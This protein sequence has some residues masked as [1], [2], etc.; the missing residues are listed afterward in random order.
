MGDEAGRVLSMV[1]SSVRKHRLAAA[2]GST[3]P[4][5]HLGQKRPLRLIRVKAEGDVSLPCLNGS[6]AIK[7]CPL[8]LPFTIPQTSKPELIPA[9]PACRILT[10][11]ASPER[12]TGLETGS[13]ALGDGIAVPG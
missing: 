13:P 2:R 9:R 11:V 8:N 12:G 7:G 10:P 4:A 5:T 1:A 6:L 3:S